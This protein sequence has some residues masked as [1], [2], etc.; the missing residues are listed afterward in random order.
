LWTGG[1]DSCLALY[2]AELLGY[3]VESL[4]TFIPDDSEF[5]AHPLKFMNLQAEAMERPHFTLEISEPYKESYEKAIAYLREKHG[6]E[7]LIIGDIA[8]VDGH[9]NWIRE[10]SKY[11]GADVLTPLWGV[12]RHSH[13]ENLISINL[14]VIISCVK[15]PWFSEDWLGREINENS[16]AELSKLNMEMGVDISGENGEY[17]TLVL[18]GPMFKKRL[19]ISDYVKCTKDSLMYIDIK[20]MSLQEK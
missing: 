8:E 10:C 9:T 4:I 16:L 17:H 19:Q 18:D 6:I 3:E 7:I 1:K 11:S 13:M 14:R 12:D 20:K 15:Y 2:Q 5:R